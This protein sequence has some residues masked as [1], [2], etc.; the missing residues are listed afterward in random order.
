MLA[1]NQ[2][3]TSPKPLLVYQVNEGSPLNKLRAKV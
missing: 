2:Q 1:E 3:K